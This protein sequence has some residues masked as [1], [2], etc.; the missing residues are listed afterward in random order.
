M[1]NDS[2]SFF[3]A[4][5]MDDQVLVEA[6]LGRRRWVSEREAGEAARAML[7][8][9]APNLAKEAEEGQFE[10]TKLVWGLEYRTKSKA[11]HLPPP[12][13]EKGA[14]LLDLPELATGN[15]SIPHKLIQ[16]LRENQGYWCVVKPQLATLLPP[17]NALLGP[18]DAKGMAQ[19]RGSPRARELS[20]QDFEEALGLQRILFQDRDAWG[21][22]F[23]GMLEELLEIR[24]RLA[25][26]GAADRV[27]WVTG[28]ASRGS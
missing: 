5:L 4:Y 14:Y 15:R 10:E 3:S 28:D 23:Q 18:P 9:D 2:A 25:L 6:D 1:W 11:V 16:E 21:S 8:K 20:W 7:G 19:P 24:E 17:T 22:R 27:V 12:K 26:P 13:V